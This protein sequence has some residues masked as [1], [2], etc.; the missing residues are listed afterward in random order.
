M[1]ITKAIE[2]KDI[3]RDKIISRYSN[4]FSGLEKLKG[5]QIKLNID[6][7]QSPKVR[8]QRVSLVHVREKVESALEEL[9]NNDIIERV[10]ENQ[11]TAWVY[12]IVVVPK[13]DGNVR[14]CVDIRHVNDA[15]KR[16]RH[17]IP[18]VSGAQ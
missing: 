12:P 16:V 3:K 10:P 9:E 14:I 18:T 15:I 5:E 4:Y 1:Y 11:P 2:S 6:Q 17:P 7:T 8:P 13:K